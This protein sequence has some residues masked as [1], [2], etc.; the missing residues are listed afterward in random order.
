MV[1]NS[2]HSPARYAYLTVEN[3]EA[4]SHE[5][6]V[7]Q[8]YMFYSGDLNW[9]RRL[10]SHA[11][12]SHSVLPLTPAQRQCFCPVSLSASPLKWYWFPRLGLHF[13]VAPSLQHSP[14]TQAAAPGACR[15]A[16]CP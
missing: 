2:Q 9:G 3:I 13:L 1:S 5:H 12:F 15:P 14:N 7:A 11:C 6:R 10:Q 16:P 8:G 4:Q